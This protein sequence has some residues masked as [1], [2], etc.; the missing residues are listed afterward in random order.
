MRMKFLSL[1]LIAGATLAGC[2]DDPSKP[3][4]KIIGGGFTNSITSNTVIYSFVAKRMKALP[5]G[6][7]L[8]ATFDLP[9]SNKKFVTSTPEN[10]A[11]DRYL[12]ESEPIHGLK[13]GVPL[14]VTL[15]LLV[16][17]QGNEIAAF[18]KIFISDTDQAPGQ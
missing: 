12:F 18:E 6:S 8:E 1:L 17:D 4:M 16:S 14:K 13:A 3:Y 9:D 5:S 2:G 15:R 10:P 11:K 7:Y